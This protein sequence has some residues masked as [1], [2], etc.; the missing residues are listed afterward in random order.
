M[1]SFKAP[2]VPEQEAPIQLEQAEAHSKADR[3]PAKDMGV[4][5]KAVTSKSLDKL[6]AALDGPAVPAR[7]YFPEHIEVWVLDRL[8]PDDATVKQ[9]FF[10]HYQGR[11]AIKDFK[12]GAISYEAPA[13]PQRWCMPSRKVGSATRRMT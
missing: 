5:K 13:L 8:E 9:H 2:A 7:Y 10:D 4:P 3:I 6:P 1:P 11:I 12:T